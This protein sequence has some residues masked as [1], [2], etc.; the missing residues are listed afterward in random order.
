M[1]LLRAW[2]L[3][4]GTL[5][6][7][8]LTAPAV[9]HS[10]VPTLQCLR[11][12]DAHEFAQPVSTK[13]VLSFSAAWE[14]PGAPE[15][16]ILFDLVPGEERVVIGE[17]PL[18]VREES[19]LASAIVP[20]KLGGGGR[21]L[22]KEVV[23]MGDE[24]VRV[25]VQ[26]MQSF[27]AKPAPQLNRVH[28]EEERQQAQIQKMLTTREQQH[29]ADAACA[30]GS[31]SGS[32]GASPL[33]PPVGGSDDDLS[34][35]CGDV[36]ASSGSGHLG[37]GGD[38]TVAAA[39]ASASAA[40]ASAST[41]S[42]STPSSGWVTAV[43]NGGKPRLGRAHQKLDANERRL[44]A[45]LWS[46]RLNADKAQ[47]TVTA[48]VRQA[49][50]RATGRGGEHLASSAA[51]EALLYAHRI[52]GSG[53]S[54]AHEIAK[55]VDGVAFGYGG[56][57]AYVSHAPQR[58]APSPLSAFYTRCPHHCKPLDARTTEKSASYGC[59]SVRVCH[60]GVYP[61]LLHAKGELVKTHAVRYSIGAAGRYLLH[62]GLRKQGFSLPGSPFHIEVK[63]GPAHAPSSTLPP[64][65]LPLRSVV[66]RGGQLLLRLS[67]N[68]GNQCIEGGAPLA[69]SLSHTNKVITKG[70][71]PSP[72]P[73]CSSEDQGD[74]SYQISWSGEHT[75][76][77][78]MSITVDSV[79][80]RGSP[81][82]LTLLP[83]AASIA[84]CEVSGEGL[85]S[86]V[87]GRPA[88]IMIRCR[89]QFG[90]IPDTRSAELSF[91]LVLLTVTGGSVGGHAAGGPSS[92]S[93]GDRAGPKAGQ[94]PKAGSAHGANNPAGAGEARSSAAAAAAERATLAKSQDSI[95]YSGRWIHEDAEYIITYVPTEAAD[96]EMHVWCCDGDGGT[97]V[98]GIAAGPQETAGKQPAAAGTRAHG[99]GSAHA[100]SGRQLLP[101]SPFKL[102][103]SAGPPSASGSY[104][105]DAAAVTSLTAGERLDCK[106]QL[107]DEHGNHAPL[108]TSSAE[109]DLSVTLRMPNEQSLP[110]VAKP[111]NSPEAGAAASRTTETRARERSTA[112]LSTSSRLSSPSRGLTWST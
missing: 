98:A 36:G 47:A 102:H 33:A 93:S 106:I 90:N 95:D 42:A 52:T 26:I 55:C 105:R 40:S 56:E 76:T 111:V 43:K 27:A 37:S 71:T 11:H 2:L 24:G 59:A 86:A 54:F 39:S 110:L 91:G 78:L 81:T 15:T 30:S 20:I 22:I 62:V 97:E 77:F 19:S 101:N 58:T 85:T 70:E 8:L 29:R 46:K 16:P 92:H 84:K 45:E 64:E 1:G 75:G 79:H 48:Q 63:P 108:S 38:A 107:T 57:C 35:F 60:T 10:V 89:D 41:P 88:Q 104:I 3:L 44:Q 65:V 49:E 80:V 53:P 28:Q 50:G 100:G 14:P 23:D 32:Q 73:S 13:G 31:P 68:V 112:A 109:E 94:Q 7:L 67:D 51:D 96:F 82:A 25:H 4:R 61:G 66:G 34:T 103:V 21:V 5:L 99:S 6:L 9:F 83:A 74:G 17:K 72:T 69:V 18:V 87:A 12:E